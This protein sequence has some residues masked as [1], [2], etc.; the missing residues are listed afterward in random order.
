MWAPGGAVNTLQDLTT[1]IV[2]LCESVQTLVCCL[3]EP[4]G[5]VQSPRQWPQ[6]SSNRLTRTFSED[7]GQS[8]CKSPSPLMLF[9]L[10]ANNEARVAA[11]RENRDLESTT[12]GTLVTTGLKRLS[13]DRVG[14]WMRGSQHV[15]ERNDECLCTVPL[16]C[17]SLLSLHR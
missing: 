7:A 11:S 4:C 6:C 16:F 15:R 9:F 8:D 2:S 1:R 14:I 12:A 17:L 13:K 10:R 5:K 3:R